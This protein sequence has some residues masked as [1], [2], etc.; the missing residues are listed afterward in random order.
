[1]YS[2]KQRIAALIGIILLAALYLLTLVFAVFDLDG[3]GNLFKT[4]LF[5]TIALPIL[6]W[7]YIWMYGIWRRKHTP[8]SFDFMEGL[9]P[10]SP[11]DLTDTPVLGDMPETQESEK[12]KAGCQ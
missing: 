5:A 10:E 11:S 4:S 8:A 3:S 12:E 7:V 1:M 6:I 9:K 2:K